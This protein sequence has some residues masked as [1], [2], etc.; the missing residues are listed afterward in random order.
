MAQ[1]IRDIVPPTLIVSAWGELL[2][3]QLA[4]SFSAIGRVRFRVGH[5]RS[6]KLL[7]ILGYLS[8][9]DKPHYL[10]QRHCSN[11]G[12]SA[13]QTMIWIQTVCHYFC[14]ARERADFHLHHHSLFADI[15]G[16]P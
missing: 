11:L 13:G 3:S 15:R 1:V 10:C 4:K 5:E 2:K 7:D 9:R 8:Q 16:Q 6:A 14:V 12:K